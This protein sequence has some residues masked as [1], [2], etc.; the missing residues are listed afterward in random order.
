M[1]RPIIRSAER[2]NCSPVRQSGLLSGDIH[3]PAKCNN[4]ESPV[5]AQASASPSS[6]FGLADIIGSSIA[7]RTKG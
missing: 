5:R 2:V 4:S 6:Q 7:Y 1:A 3:L